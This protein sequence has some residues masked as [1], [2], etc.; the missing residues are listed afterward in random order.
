MYCFQQIQ[1]CY[2]SPNSS[3]TPTL[4]PSHAMYFKIY[5]DTCKIYLLMPVCVW[6]PLR[7]YIHNEK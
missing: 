1:P 7:A 2:F 6:W 5:S 4:F 3:Y